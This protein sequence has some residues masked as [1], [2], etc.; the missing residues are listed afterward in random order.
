MKRIGTKKHGDNTYVPTRASSNLPSCIS[1]RP[2]TSASRNVVG[3]GISSFD[4]DIEVIA[5]SADLY[6]ILGVLDTLGI[7]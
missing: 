3:S 6:V 7:E 4:I 1:R 5:D 2:S